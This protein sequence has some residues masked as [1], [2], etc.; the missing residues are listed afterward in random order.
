MKYFYHATSYDNLMPILKDGI[1]ARNAE[2]LVYMAE[3]AE[4][5]AK[6]LWIRGVPK[7]LCVKVKIPKSMEHNIMETFDHSYNFFKC[8]SFGY[9]GDITTDMLCSTN[10]WVVFDRNK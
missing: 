10:T 4:D 2:R 5:A 9:S 8:R 7:I 3:T 6:F 1:L